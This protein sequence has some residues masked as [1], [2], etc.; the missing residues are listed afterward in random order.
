[1]LLQQR[2]SDSSHDPNLLPYVSTIEIFTKRY[3]D[4]RYTA[5]SLRFGFHVP[6]TDI[7]VDGNA[8]GVLVEFSEHESAKRNH[9][10]SHKYDPICRY[11][12]FLN[13]SVSQQEVAENKV[14]RT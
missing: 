13:S 9:F 11:F 6:Q 8:S 3:V 2:S 5:L 14:G 7:R 12:N 1:M 4:R 10:Y